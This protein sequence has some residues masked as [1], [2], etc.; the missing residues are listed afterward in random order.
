MT[1]V[2]YYED[3][4]SELVAFLSDQFNESD[5]LVATKVPAPDETNLPPNFL[6]LTVS[7]GQDKTP[8][9][10]YYGVVLELYAVDYATASSLSREVDFWLR[11][12]TAAPSVKAVRVING[13]IRL[14]DEGPKEKR[15][16][17]A[18]LVVKAWTN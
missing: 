11:N 3:I 9:T 1:S 10:R 14:G 18:E 2:I 5:V 7:P 17:S 15:S 16:F 12:A 13:P 8:V 6:I 4:E